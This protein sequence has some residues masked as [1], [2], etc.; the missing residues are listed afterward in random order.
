MHLETKRE[1]RHRFVLQ[2]L[3]VLTSSQ[4]SEGRGR[5]WCTGA[6][7]HWQ[8]AGEVNSVFNVTENKSCFFSLHTNEGSRLSAE[9]WPARRQLTALQTESVNVHTSL[10]HNQS[11]MIWFDQSLTPPGSTPAQTLL[12]VIFLKREHY[13]HSLITWGFFFFL[14]FFF[15]FPHNKESHTRMES[16]LP[17][18]MIK[19]Q[20][21]A[22]LQA[23]QSRCS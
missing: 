1:T 23:G 10:I 7:A 12:S 16:G 11:Q 17:P 6:L 4:A 20:T 3:I 2:T 13:K 14:C 15:F 19:L 18:W 22:R 21:G 9:A 8:E 5:R